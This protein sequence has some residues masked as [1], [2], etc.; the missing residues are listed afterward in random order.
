[1][2]PFVSAASG[3]ALF[4]ARFLLESFFCADCL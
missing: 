1:L 3:R 2:L 4:C